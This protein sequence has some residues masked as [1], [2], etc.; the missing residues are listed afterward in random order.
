MTTDELLALDQVDRAER[1]LREVIRS[2][3]GTTEA[4]TRLAEAVHDDAF[5]VGLENLLGPD[6]ALDAYWEDLEQNID[7]PLGPG[8]PP[9][10]HYFTWRRHEPEK[11][12]FWRGRYPHRKKVFATKPKDFNKAAADGEKIYRTP[13]AAKIAATPALREALTPEEIQ[14]DDDEVLEILLLTGAL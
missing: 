8:A 2:F 1:R 14:R 10:V 7:Q 4:W 12:S 13:S 6:F 5:E 9:I 3:D 11:H